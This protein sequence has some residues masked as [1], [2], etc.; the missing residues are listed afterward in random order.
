MNLKNLGKFIPQRVVTAVMGFLSIIVAYA[1]RTC[2][3]V[4]ITE[5]V[6][7]V[8]DRNNDNKSL[9]CEALYL[10]ANYARF[11]EDNGSSAST[12]R[13]HLLFDQGNFS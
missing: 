13:Q 11:H 4:A 8:I 5:M 10:S 12:V 2:L 3:S 1:M 6:V 7:P 9:V